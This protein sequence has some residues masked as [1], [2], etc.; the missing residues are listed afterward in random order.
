LARILIS[1]HK[2]LIKGIQQK[3]GDEALSL[4]VDAAEVLRQALGIQQGHL[5]IDPG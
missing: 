1:I 4:P 3:P 2:I 5:H